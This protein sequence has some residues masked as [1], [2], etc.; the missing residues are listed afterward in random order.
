[1]EL[2]AN[3]NCGVASTSDDELIS[4][5]ILGCGVDPKS[6]M[7]QH[8]SAFYHAKTVGLDF[9]LLQNNRDG[10]CQILG[11]ICGSRVYKNRQI[12]CM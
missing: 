7:D 10:K 9:T 12:H 8:P 5:W 1:M 2:G 11:A 6:I 3:M 4:L